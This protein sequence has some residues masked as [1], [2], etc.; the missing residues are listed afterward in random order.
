M[1]EEVVKVER[2]KEKAHKGPKKHKTVLNKVVIRRLPPNFT[3]EQFLIS[4]QPTKFDDFYFVKA[5]LSLGVEAT[6]RAYIEMKSQD[7]VSFHVKMQR[8]KLNK[9]F[10]RF[11]CLRT[12]LMAMF[13]LIPLEALNI[14]QSLSMHHFKAYLNH[15]HEKINTSL[16]LKMNNTS[17]HSLKTL[18][19]LKIM[20]IKRVKENWSLHF[21]SRMTKKSHQLHCSNSWQLLRRKNVRQ[22]R[23]KLTIRRSKGMRKN[24]VRKRKSLKM[25]QSQ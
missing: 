24:N 5:D 18:R 1:P 10:F 6:S 16:L 25:S 2:D 4:I 13:F 11:F 20:K 21:N 3:E 12:S 9:Y 7:E 15:E 23:R 14:Q 17:R 19:R 8:L 22:K